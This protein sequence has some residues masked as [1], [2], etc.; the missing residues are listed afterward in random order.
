MPFAWPNTSQACQTGSVWN[1]AN[2]PNPPIALCGAVSLKKNG[3]L[4]CKARNELAPGRQNWPLRSRAAHGGTGTSRGRSERHSRAR[5]AIISHRALRFQA[6]CLFSGA[7]QNGQFGSRF[8]TRTIRATTTP[9]DTANATTPAH[10][11]QRRCA[12]APLRTQFH[13]RCT[14]YRVYEWDVED[15]SGSSRFRRALGR[16]GIGWRESR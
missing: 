1:R 8:E 13:L 4:G 9:R 11:N 5:R 15:G 16:R 7:K 14:V 2:S 6:H 10:V 3:S 12:A